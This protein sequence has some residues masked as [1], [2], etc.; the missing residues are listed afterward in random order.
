MGSRTSTVSQKNSM[1]ISFARCHT[2]SR[3]SID[4]SCTVSEIQNTGHS[5]RTSPYEIIQARF[6][7]KHDGH[8]LCAMLRAES[9]FDQFLVHL[10]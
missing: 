9:S 6:C 4:F 7:E 2:E 10:V 5:R 1:V 8:Q 3:V